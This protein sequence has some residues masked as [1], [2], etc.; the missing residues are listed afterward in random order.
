MHNLSVT[1]N[2]Q[3]DNDEMTIFGCLTLSPIQQS[4]SRQH[5]EKILNVHSAERNEHFW[6]FENI[7]AKE[8]MF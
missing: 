6:S 2:C 7:V 8:E 3:N 4:C 1:A 5:L